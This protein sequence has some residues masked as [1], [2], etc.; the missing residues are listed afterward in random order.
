MAFDRCSLYQE[1]ARLSES[2]GSLYRD[3]I[4]GR[5][6]LLEFMD[7]NG[8]FGLVPV[9]QGQD[10]L[11]ESMDAFRNQLE[12]WLKA[13]KKT[14]NEKISLMLEAYDE[15]LPDTCDRGIKGW[16]DRRGCSG[17]SCCKD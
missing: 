16:H 12:L 9:F 8:W 7:M 5:D 13:Y 17:V 4:P 14:G 6:A 11:V 10:V 2:C 3:T 15:V 1:T